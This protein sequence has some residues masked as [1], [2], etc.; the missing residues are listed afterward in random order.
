MK[1]VVPEF[2]KRIGYEMILDEEQLVI[3]LKSDNSSL[4]D[5]TMHIIKCMLKVGV[6]VVKVEYDDDISIITYLSTEDEVKVDMLDYEWV[7]LL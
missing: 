5:D 3:I 7:K 4:V 2:R 1:Y 6:N